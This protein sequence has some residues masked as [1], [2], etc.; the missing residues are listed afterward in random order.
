MT[1]EFI[2][3]ELVARGI[4]AE[5]TEVTKNGVVLKGIIL[6]EG[7]VRPTVYADMYEDAPE[8]AIEMLVKRVKE[9]LEE[10][11]RFNTEDLTNWDWVKTR[12]RLCI[13]QKGNE[14]ICKR[15]FS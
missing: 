15:D 5:A 11:P 8:S 3:G 14:P 9:I 7:S 1:R 10:A 13:Q 12:L 4:K 6:G 2:I